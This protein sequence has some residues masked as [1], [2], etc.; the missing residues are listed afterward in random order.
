MVILLFEFGK[1]VNLLIHPLGLI[2]EK[3]KIREIINI[4]TPPLR[5]NISLK[6]LKLPKNHFETNFVFVQLKHLKA[7]F[8]FGKTLKI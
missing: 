7:T 2:C 3:F 5:K 1:N 8:T 4:G 6:Q